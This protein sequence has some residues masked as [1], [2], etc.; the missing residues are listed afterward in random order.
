LETY[1]ITQEIIL[2]IVIITMVLMQKSS[3]IGLGA[4]NGGDMPVNTTG[5]FLFRLSLAVVFAFVINTVALSYVVTTQS[6]VSVV[7]Q[8]K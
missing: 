1:L 6:N 3:S 7:D 4:Y 5:Q 2:S 8:I